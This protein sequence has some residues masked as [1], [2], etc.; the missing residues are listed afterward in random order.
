MAKFSKQYEQGY[1]DGRQSKV[2]DQKYNGWSNYETWVVKLWMNNDQ[3][4]S[5]YWQS[6]TAE[7]CSPDSPE[8][9]ADE[10]SRKCAIADRLKDEHEESK[11]E[12]EGVFSDLLNAAFSEVDWYEI[13]TALVTDYVSEAA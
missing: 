5:E 2:N 11:P 8:Y 9:I 12:L 4:T 7:L 1:A 6:I 3:G 10:N 13:A